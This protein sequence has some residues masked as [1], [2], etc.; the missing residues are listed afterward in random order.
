MHCQRR[1]AFSFGGCSL[2]KTDVKARKERERRYGHLYTLYKP[3]GDRC[4]YCGIVADSVDHCPPI[5]ALYC[6]GSEYYNRKGIFLVKVPA[7]RECNSALGAKLLETLASRRQYMRIWLDKRYEQLI[8]LPKWSNDE[9]EELG[10]GLH[11]FI[12]DREGLRHWIAARVE[13]S[14]LDNPGEEKLGQAS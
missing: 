4:Y 13:W 9:F 1:E 8:T 7:C 12:G 5:N 2:T 11:E 6:M 3:H 10:D 14:R